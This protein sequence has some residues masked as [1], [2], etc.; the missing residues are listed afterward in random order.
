[1]NFILDQGQKAISGASAGNGT[2]D[3]GA[4][5]KA[6]EQYGQNIGKSYLDDYMNRLL[7]YSQL[8]LGSAS[9]LSGAGSQS[10]SVGTSTGNSNSSSFGYG[11]GSSNLSSSSSGT[12]NSTGHSKNGLLPDLAAFSPGAGSGAAAGAGG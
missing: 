4:T 6:L 9:A 12:G 7:G 2:F 8:G 3:S 1:M 5:G 10:Q 11:S